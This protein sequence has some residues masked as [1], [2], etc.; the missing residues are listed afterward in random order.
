MID[1]SREIINEERRK[2]RVMKSSY[3]F[4]PQ[5]SNLLE[6]GKALARDYQISFNKLLSLLVENAVNEWTVPFMQP[7]P[8]RGEE[9]AAPAN[10]GV[11]PNKAI[12]SH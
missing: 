3:P 12:D 6:E 11:F 2:T 8:R 5:N 7:R 10:E 1:K 9:P 4:T